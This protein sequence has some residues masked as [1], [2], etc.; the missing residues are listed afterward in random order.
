VFWRQPVATG[1]PAVGSEHGKGHS[2]MMAVMVRMY[3][4]LIH[5]ILVL[6]L[7]VHNVLTLPA[8]PALPC[9]LCCFAA[10]SHLIYYASVSF[11]HGGRRVC[12]WQR[13]QEWREGCESE[14]WADVGRCCCGGHDGGPW[15]GI[16][17]GLC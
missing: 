2:M 4:V 7:V 17:Q 6:V 16:G 3:V 13:R 9:S 5:R 8:V 1:L 10:L 15:A 12:R 11:S 14:V